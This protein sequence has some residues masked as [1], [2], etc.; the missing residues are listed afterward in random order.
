[1]AVAAGVV[2]GSTRET[3]WRSAA[4]LLALGVG[5]YAILLPVNP[6]WIEWLYGPGVH[7]PIAAEYR[8]SWNNLRQQPGSVD[9]IPVDIRNIGITKWRA[10]GL[11]HSAIG[12]RWWNIASETFLQTNPIITELP[13]DVGRGETTDIVAHFQ[14]PDQPG[15]YLLVI[16]LFS[17]D[18][19]W[20]SRIG[21]VPAL[22]QV[23]VQAGIARS[24]DEIDLSPFYHRRQLPDVFT[25]SVPR[26]D[27]WRAALKI[28]RAHPFGIGPDNYRLEYGKYIG[29]TRWDTHL[30]S[31]NLFLEILTG[32]GILGFAAFIWFLM[33]IPWRF[34]GE[35]LGI[36]IFLIHGL[37]DVFLMTTPVYFA[38]WL[39]LGTRLSFAA[40]RTTWDFRDYPD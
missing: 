19:D 12:Y 23:D 5:A 31:N 37:V 11:W 6:Y 2:L 8:T 40:S 13:H 35:S 15:K 17:R 26:S 18:F 34:D 7:N 24:A 21:V 1:M 29:A 16:E 20:F 38:F 28:I 30:Y 4:A 22:V 9:E 10:R 39:L 32:S 25:V 36:A 27:L 14:T 3:K 33:A